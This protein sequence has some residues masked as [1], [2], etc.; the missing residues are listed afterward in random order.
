MLIRVLHTGEQLHRP[1]VNGEARDTLKIPCIARYQR[2]SVLE[3]DGG[4]AKIHVFD[5]ELLGFQLLEPGDG[6]LCEA[7]NPKSAQQRDGIRQSLV[8][9]RQLLGALRAS[10]E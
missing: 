2:T 5:A 1:I 6:R 3:A 4:D 9:A 7:K 10:Q 8:S